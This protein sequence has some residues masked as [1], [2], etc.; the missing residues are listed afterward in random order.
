MNGADILSNQL[1]PGL[2]EIEPARSH[3]E[4]LGHQDQ[5]G[6]RLRRHLVHHVAAMLL[7]R[8]LGDA[9]LGRNLFVKETGRRQVRTP[10]A[11]AESKSRQRVFKRVD[12]GVGGLQIEAA[13][14]GPPYRI[15]QGRA[16]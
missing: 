7:Y 5:I 3:A 13:L 14:A 10:R 2:R 9:E 11:R 4:S 8:F 12:L 6:Q 15:D 16:R 1:A